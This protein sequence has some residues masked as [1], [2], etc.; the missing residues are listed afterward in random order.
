MRVLPLGGNGLI[1]TAIVA[2]PVERDAEVH[3]W[4][5]GLSDDR[6]PANVVQ[7]VVDPREIHWGRGAE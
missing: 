1:S 4:N 5:R 2:Q 3:V 6:R 7:R